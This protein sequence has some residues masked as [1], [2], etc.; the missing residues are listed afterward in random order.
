MRRFLR[1]LAAI[2]QG[3]KKMAENKREK[4]EPEPELKL[5]IEPEPE[6]G[7]TLEQI[8]DI[9]FAEELNPVKLELRDLAKTIEAFRRQVYRTAV[10][11]PGNSD[12][13]PEPVANPW[14]NVQ[15]GGAPPVGWQNL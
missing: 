10:K 8:L 6:P 14:A 9:R 5:E 7:L 15:P 11:A 2:G 13:E 4:L 3:G 12:A 1:Y